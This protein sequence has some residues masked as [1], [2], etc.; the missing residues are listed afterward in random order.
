MITI[1][2]AKAENFANLGLG[3]LAP[4]ECKVTWE[5]G[6]RYDLT[7]K[8]PIL[9]DGK[10][11]MIGDDRIIRAPSPVRESPYVEQTAGSS[12][13]Q[14][15]TRRIYRVKTPKGGRLNLRK[16]ASTNSKILASYKPGK[17][18]IAVET[19]G[20]W[21]RVIVI[22]GGKAGWMYTDYLQ[23]VRDE[24]ET[25]ASGDKPGTVIKRRQAGDQLFRIT[26]YESDDAN[27]LVLVNAEHISYDLGR[28]VVI[29]KCDLEKVPVAT[30]LAK[31]QELASREH[32]FEIHCL[33]T[34]N[35]TGDYTNKSLLEC[36]RD[37]KIGFAPQLGARVVCDNF[38][39]W[40]LPD[41][42][43]DLGVV[44]R[45]RKNLLGVKMKTDT[46][47]RV[48]RIYPVGE[49]E[50]GEPL[51]LDG[52][53][54]VE[55]A[56]AAD[57]VERDTVIKY[58][59]KVGDGEDEFA[60]KKTARAELKRLAAEDMEAGADAKLVSLDVNFL[61][62]GD[63][64]EYERYKHLEV[65]HPYDTVTV[66]RG[67]FGI[68]EKARLNKCVMNGLTKKYE[69]TTFGAVQSETTTMY[70]FNIASG[71]VKNS[72]IAAGAVGAA[73]LRSASI[74]YAKIA[75]AAIEQL[76]ANAIT[77]LRAHINELVAG[78]V[79]TDQLYADLAVI[80]AAQI[81]AANID[82]ANIDWAEI[83]TLNAQIAEIAEATI[84]TADIKWAEIATLNAQIASIAQA[85]IDNAEITS[86]QIT[87]LEA[88]VASIFSAKIGSADI[89]FAQIKDLVTQ[90]AII[91]EGV[92]GQ[93]YMA[94][95]AVTEANMVSL[96]VG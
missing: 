90:Q 6:G 13:S 1:Y 92:G 25:V 11:M 73:Q 41:E 80:A 29:G 23:Y 70:S 77:A 15:V 28:V 87:D 18:V 63:T 37:P 74:Q 43:R 44:L 34:G 79:T 26:D 12:V 14:T 10:W 20:N 86:A 42:V 84:T 35:V 9:D 95:L 27:G 71:A 22:E 72:Q 61:D 40:I 16:S 75:Q 82:N 19:S 2:D 4:T 64:E 32:D 66:I 58:D 47:S 83:A 36:I 53:K 91:T 55:S 51:Y 24:T 56:A 76:S 68:K 3:A 5:E 39:V 49:D 88:T 60:D 8:Q 31:V 57:M 85:K 46:S 17:E 7:L 67:N 48:S 89:G 52:T 38:D 96:T 45:Y 62:L 59:V 30:A 50:D 78:S 94:R 65:V 33:V 81:T 93:L 21:T 54:Y 69:S